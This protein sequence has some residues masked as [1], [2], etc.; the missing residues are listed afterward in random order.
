MQVHPRGGGDSTRRTVHI[1]LTCG[2]RGRDKGKGV[3][4]VCVKAFMA[5]YQVVPKHYRYSDRR[6]AQ[7]FL[8]CFRPVLSSPTTR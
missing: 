2:T 1:C 4:C 5:L 8:L 3:V 7:F 6:H